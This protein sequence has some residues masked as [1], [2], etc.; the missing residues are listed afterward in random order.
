MRRKDRE[1]TDPGRIREIISACQCCRIGLC[2]QGRAYIVPL[3]FGYTEKDGR[4]TFY[5]H[6]A[7]EGR[8]ISLIAQNGYAA[9]EMDRAHQLIHGEIACKYSARYQCVMGGGRISFVEDPAEKR[10]GLTAIMRQT[11]GKDQWEFEEKM[12]GVVCV[13]KLEAEELSCKERG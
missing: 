8:K 9:F 12:L 10:T 3:N 1:V 5:F 11:T 13:F 6:S 7:K 4:Y 2:D